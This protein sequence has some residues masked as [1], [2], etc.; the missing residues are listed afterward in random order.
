MSDRL[1][2][3]LLGCVVGLFVGGVAGYLVGRPTERPP[4]EPTVQELAE[5]YRADQEAARLRSLPAPEPADECD[6]PYD[7]ETF[8]GFEA[9][10]GLDLAASGGERP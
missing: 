9:R 5:H 7:W 8:E 10:C 1:T 4:P 2:P 3:A 6:Y